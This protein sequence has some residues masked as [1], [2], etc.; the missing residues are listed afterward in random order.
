MRRNSFQVFVGSTKKGLFQLKSIFDQM[1]S[2]DL[3]PADQILPQEPDY[4]PLIH[5]IQGTCEHIRQKLNREAA[6]LLDKL[7][8]D[9][10]S[11]SSMN[12]CAG[13]SYGLKL[14]VRFICEVFM[15]YNK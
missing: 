3:S 14:G 12:C 6:E 9:F 13:F 10:Y 11:E 2:G 15:E 4:W 8:D 5:E 7:C 1:Y